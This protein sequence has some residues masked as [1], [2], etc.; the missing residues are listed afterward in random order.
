MRGGDRLRGGAK[1]GDGGL[2]IDFGGVVI[3]GV[4]GL[5]EGGLRMDLGA[6]GLIGEVF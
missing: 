4:F 5:G 2:R 3:V 1:V 6:V